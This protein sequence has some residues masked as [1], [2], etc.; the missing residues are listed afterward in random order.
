MTETTNAVMGTS[1]L[2]T[3]ITDFE[4][5]KQPQGISLPLIRTIDCAKANTAN[6]RALQYRLIVFSFSTINDTPVTTWNPI[7]TGTAQALSTVG[8]SWYDAKADMNRYG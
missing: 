6:S 4:N 7:N 3:L 2:L 1:A 5:P 8:T